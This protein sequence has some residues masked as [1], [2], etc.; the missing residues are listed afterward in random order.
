MNLKVATTKSNTTKSSSMKPPKVGGRGG[1]SFISSLFEVGLN[2]D[3]G[4]ICVNGLFNLVK[5]MVSAVH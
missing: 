2:R 3:R 4:L 1:G 5:R